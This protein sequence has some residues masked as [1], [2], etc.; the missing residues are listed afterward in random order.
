MGRWIWILVCLLAL[1]P[2]AGRITMMHHAV[3]GS[4][5]ATLLAGGSIFMGVAVLVV[6]VLIAVAAAGIGARFVDA[7]TGC[8]AGASIFGWAAW[9][10]GQVDAVLRMKGG[11]ALWVLCIESLLLGLAVIA[12]V[13]VSVIVQP[14]TE[15]QR[16]RH[17]NRP[18]IPADFGDL[19]RIQAL[20]LDAPAQI[21]I[22]AGAAIV[23]GAAN[24]FFF[25]SEFH[26]GQG[27]A[28]AMFAAVFGVGVARILV[29]KCPVVVPVAGL[30]VLAVVVFVVAGVMHG[31]KVMEAIASGGYVRF[32][33]PAPLDWAAG[34]CLGIP[35]GRAFG[36]SFGPKEHVASSSSPAGV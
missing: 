17:K 21:A 6:V 16:A 20:R 2:L 4:S 18:F 36:D 8:L 25:A 22:A 31:S 15:V 30:V 35:M 12:V 19:A 7:T 32:A 13:V 5:N 1:G 3:D 11:G 26:H 27:V 10:S 34:L 24:A 28:A 23:L 29:P 33:R 9:S 14:S